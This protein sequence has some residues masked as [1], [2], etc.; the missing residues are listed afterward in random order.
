MTSDHG[1][2]PMYDSL[3]G[4]LLEQGYQELELAE[5][6]RGVGQRLLAVRLHRFPCNRAFVFAPPKGCEV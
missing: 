3:T 4:W 2:A 5:L 1:A 6:A